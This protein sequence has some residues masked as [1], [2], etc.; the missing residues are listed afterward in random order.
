MR[1]LDF[2]DLSQH[3]DLLRLPDGRPI[4]VRFV[5]SQDAEA[6]QAYVRALSEASRYSRFFGAVNGLPPGELEKS[7]HSGDNNLFTVVAVTR[8]EGLERIVGE[9]RY[10][11]D[12]RLDRFEFGLSVSDHWQGHGLG[13]ALLS[14]LE[15]R[16]AALGARSIA[17]ETLRNNSAMIGLA[18]KTG[19]VFVANP[20]DWKQVRFE[21]PIDPA[22]EGIP[23]ANWR[24]AAQ[25]ARD[26]PPL[27]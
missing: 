23:C 12:P 9:A 11:I 7:I 8:F 20:S 6:L 25:S 22:P 3:V 1:A 27:H 21:K 26:V 17:G 14:N 13:R 5:T 19:Y 15:C 18:R 16:A 24:Y 4:T 2:H 10:V